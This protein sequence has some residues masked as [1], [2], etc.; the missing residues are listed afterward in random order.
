MVSY[1]DVS[2]FSSVLCQNVIGEP[3]M[4]Y[5][6]NVLFVFILTPFFLLIKNSVLAGS[7]SKCYSC[8]LLA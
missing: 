3:T 7:E 8:W 1:I 2:K 4:F 6:R 5:I